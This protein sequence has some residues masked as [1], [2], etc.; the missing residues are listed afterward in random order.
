MV[1]GRAGQRPRVLEVAFGGSFG[2]FAVFGAFV[3]ALLLVNE[4]CKRRSVVPTLLTCIKTS[5]A[6]LHM[7]MCLTVYYRLYV[8]RHILFRLLSCFLFPLPLLVG[9]SKG[10][11][12]PKPKSKVILLSLL[13]F[14]E[15]DKGQTGAGSMSVVSRKN[16]EARPVLDWGQ[17]A[18][19]RPGGDSD[20]TRLEAMDWTDCFGGGETARWNSDA[21]M[22][23]CVSDAMLPRISPNFGI[24]NIQL[25]TYNFLFVF[26]YFFSRILPLGLHVNHEKRTDCMLLAT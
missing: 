16:K 17:S 4:K 13:L 21:L 11:Q 3:D 12:L 7:Y 8:I 10:R 20:Q 25:Y 15:G 1:L 23:F 22:G 9:R 6:D 2:A 19:Q 26:Q 24:C 14:L 5:V 18:D